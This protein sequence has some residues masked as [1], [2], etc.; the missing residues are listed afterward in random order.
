[1]MCSVLTLAA[2]S[3]QGTGD[4]EF[5]K[6]YDIYFPPEFLRLFD[7]PSGNSM[8]MADVVVCAATGFTKCVGG[9]VCGST[10][11]TGSARTPA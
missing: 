11:R 3:N 1:M 2:G 8:G 5:G 4:V 10:R 6:I 9:P 7:G